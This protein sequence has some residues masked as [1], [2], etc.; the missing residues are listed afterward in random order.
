[1]RAITRQTL[2]LVVVLLAAVVVSACGGGPT[3]ICYRP[4]TVRADT[5]WAFSATGTDSIMSIVVL[6]RCDGNGGAL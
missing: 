4:E 5:S 2:A 3:G 1:M 6:Q